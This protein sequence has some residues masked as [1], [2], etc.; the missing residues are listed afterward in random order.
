MSTATRG[1]AGT[2]VRPRAATTRAAR[3]TLTGTWGLVRLMLRRDRVRLPIWLVAILGLVYSSAA[4]VRGMYGTQ[5]RLDTYAETMG[6]SAAV[7]VMSGPPTALR[8]LGGVIVYEIN[9]SVIVAVALMAIFLVVR[10]TRG[11]EETG[12]TEMLR[13][14][15]VGRHAPTAAAL[16]V[17]GGATVAV[18]AGVGAIL[19]GTGLP[20]SGSVAYGASIA[21]LGL[22]FTAVGACAAQ[23]TAHA[24]GALGMASAFLGVAFVARGIGDVGTPVLSWLSPLGWVHAVR[25][26]GDERWWPILLLLAFAAGVLL[27][28]TALTTHRDL[29]AGLV[30]PRAGRASASPRLGTGTGLAARLQRGALIGWTVGMFAGGVAFGSLSGEVA[31]FMDL[32]QAFAQTLTGLGGGLVDAFLGTM[33]SILA[34]V[35]GGFTVS[36]VLRL[37]GEET[38]GRAEPLLA[39]GL[40]RLRWLGGHLLVTACGTVLVLAAGGLGLGAAHAVVRG[41][42][43]EVPRLVLAALAY[44]PAALTLAGLGVLLVGWAPRAAPA[45]W[46]ALGWCVVIGWLGTVLDFPRWVEE[47]SPY[48]HVVLVPA[49]ALGWAPLLTL[50]AVSVGLVTLGITKLVKRDIA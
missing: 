50:C 11:E 24:R 10:H 21:A 3:G 34:L 38:A 25:P 23:A 19:L 29:G 37:R 1:S 22:A 20:V 40:S 41:D 13:S 32:N 31:E 4:A 28:T 43:A 6:G 39:T 18:A 49:E 46:A 15:V 5:A 36:S 27:L 12:R 8:T 35:A 14:T 26:Y 42:A 44:T 9:T 16:V 48:A 45:L 47:T 17:V 33:L 30:P 2:A 7:V